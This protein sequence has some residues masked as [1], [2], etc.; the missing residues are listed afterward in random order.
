MHLRH[1]INLLNINAQINKPAIPGRPSNYQPVTYK[2]QQ[3]SDARELSNRKAT[4][5]IGMNVASKVK[6]RV[7][8]GKIRSHAEKLDY[9]NKPSIVWTAV[10][11][12]EEQYD[13][14][15]QSSSTPFPR[16]EDFT[17]DRMMQAV[18]LFKEQ[19]KI[20]KRGGKII[21]D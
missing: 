12:G 8:E 14:D 16:Y 18:A 10:F 6:G 13:E 5:Y 19:V 1:D 7:Y 2:A 3:P 4:N 9:E 17:Y 11:N 20:K 21:L 15:I